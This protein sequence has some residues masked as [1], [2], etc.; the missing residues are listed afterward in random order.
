MRIPDDLVR[1]AE[2]ARTRA[3]APYSGYSVGA[4]V[5]SSDGGIHSGANV[6]NASF[7]EGWCA[8]TSA[9]AAMI[10]HGARK[11]VEICVAGP[12]H[13]E[14]LPCGGCRQRLAEFATPSV[15]VH[16]RG[17]EGTWRTILL[18]ELLPQAFGLKKG[19]EQ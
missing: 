13:T 4:A 14:T 19:K 16:V 10:T 1:A 17:D 9:I 11:I 3:H 12:P 6:E 8:E 5:R 15:P 18:G 7:P 2:A